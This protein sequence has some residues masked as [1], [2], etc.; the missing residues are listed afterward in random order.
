MRYPIRELPGSYS[1]LLMQA[2]IIQVFLQMSWSPN[3][4]WSEFYGSAGEIHEYYKGLVTKYALPIFLL[5]SLL[6]SFVRFGLGKYINLNHEVI[7]AE[8]FDDAKQWRIQIRGP[9]G[10]VFTDECDIFI[11]GGG[12]LNAWKWPSIKGLHDFR[13][14]LCHTARWPDDLNVQGKR[15][16]VIGSGSSGIQVLATIQPEVKQMYHWIRSPTW[17]TG[18]FAQQFAG[19]GGKNFKCTCAHLDSKRCIDLYT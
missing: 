17:I 2:K 1:L 15:V 12:V 13:G 16:A 8:W 18:A 4:N 3:P 10:K 7:R 19:H 6:I 5:C 9:D 14:T 11:N